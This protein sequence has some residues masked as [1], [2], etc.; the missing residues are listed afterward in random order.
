[1]SNETDEVM[2]ELL[3][4]TEEEMMEV[5]SSMT[6]G[7]PIKIKGNIYMVPESFGMFLERFIKHKLGIDA[8]PQ[9]KK[10]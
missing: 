7:F 2:E 9:D 4:L 10:N 8:I 5:L 1:M 6:N 3:G